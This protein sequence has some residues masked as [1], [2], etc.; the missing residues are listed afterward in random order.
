ML[1]KVR[2]STQC[3]A[4]GRGDRAGCDRV[5]QGMPGAECFAIRLHRS[6]SVLTQ[7]CMRK[8]KS[9]LA[10]AERASI[11][12]AGVGFEPTTFGL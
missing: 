4:Q 6:P 3:V 12:V 5:S 2:N 9:P 11:L 10:F 8:A 7:Q 1:K